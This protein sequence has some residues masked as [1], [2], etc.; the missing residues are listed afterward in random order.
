MAIGIVDYDFFHN[1]PS[2]PN[3]ECGKLI[4]YWRSHNEYTTLLRDINLER[5]RQVYFRQ[6]FPN[7]HFPSELSNKKVLYGG[8][9]FSPAAYQPLPLEIEETPP[10]FENYESYD[11]LFTVGVGGQK[12]FPKVLRAVHLRL[13]LD[14]KTIWP[15]FEKQISRKDNRRVVYI[16]HDYDLGQIDGAREIVTQLVKNEWGAGMKFP[17]CLS[18]E[19]ELFEW[20]KIPLSND[21]ANF[22][23]N[24]ILSS[25]GMAE[26]VGAQPSFLK[27]LSYAI[28][29]SRFGENR[30][31]EEVF[32][33]IYT[34]AL[35]LRSQPQKILLKI[36]PDFG[37]GSLFQVISKWIRASFSCT[38]FEYI[39]FLK[40][41]KKISTAE[42]NSLR[43]NFQY[44]RENNYALFTLFYSARSASLKGGKFEPVGNSETN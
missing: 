25:E 24:G 22:H 44:I 37:L 7:V 43:E 35:F 15:Q 20:R 17:V 31:L 16:F 28:I 14:G 2:I 10:S 36:E 4:A 41:R 42:L 6:D 19:K 27:S 21:L 11:G 32:P 13:S 30:F 1:A 9:F 34:Q 33:E 18:D 29:P 40:G 8:R 5:Y 23:F 39:T 12:T 3:L 26:L 38:L